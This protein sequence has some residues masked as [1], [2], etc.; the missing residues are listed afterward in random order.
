MEP[1][2]PDASML[3]FTS[4]WGPMATFRLM[5]AKQDCPYMECIYDVQNKVLAVLSKDQVDS[6][7]MV[8]KL[9]D[10]GNRSL[11]KARGKNAPA[12][13]PN[14]PNASYKMERRTIHSPQEYYIRSREEIELFVNTFAINA[15]DFDFAQFLNM[16][17]PKMEGAPGPDQLVGPDNQPINSE[18]KQPEAEKPVAEA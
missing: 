1:T 17:P 7:K 10:N 3:M 14:D 5:P 8:P 13:D 18:Q 12:P 2:F 4:N 11:I 6:F 16:E 15:K 9:D